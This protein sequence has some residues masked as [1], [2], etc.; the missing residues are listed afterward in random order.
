MA[1]VILQTKAHCPPFPFVIQIGRAFINSPKGVR[2]PK[3]WKET[4]GFYIKGTASWATYEK[5]NIRCI[6]ESTEYIIKDPKLMNTMR[7]GF[8]KRVPGFN[9]LVAGIKRM[10]LAKLSNKELYGL[11]IRFNSAYC[12]TY[13]W[14]EPFPFFIKES[15]AEHLLKYL[16][17]KVDIGKAHKYLNV[18]CSP[19]EISFIKR[20]ERDMLKL[21][22]KI[23][24][25]P[26]LK[27]RLLEE[28]TKDYFWIPYDY[29]P[30]L[31]TRK[32]F[33]EELGDV[34]KNKDPARE[35]KKLNDYYTNLKKE[36][37]RII[38]E[39]DIDKRHQQ[40]FEDV[41]ICAFIMDY[42]KE[43][44]TKSHF[45]AR[46]LLK[47]TAKRL[48]LSFKGVQYISEHEMKEGLIDGKKLDKGRMEKRENLSYIYYTRKS[49][50]LID[51]EKAG[52]FIADLKKNLKKEGR[53]IKGM[54]A[55]SGS[56]M[57]RVSIVMHPR[58]LGKMK[59]GDVLV[60]NMTSPDFVVG[61]KKAGAIVTNEGGITSHAAIVSREMGIPCIIGTK[62][63]SKVLKD[64]DIVEVDAN[65][66]IV[67]KVK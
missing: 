8:L 50:D 16:I 54:P 17:K 12:N 57:G 63:A 38:K 47:E 44:F 32:H 13:V 11:W 24:K 48:G 33:E 25:N 49:I 37:K 61:M 46:P 52:R 7:K 43:V 18:L 59:K 9:R 39:L 23:R 41:R 58:G 55:C 56:Y 42:K 26:K 28:H 51:G 67:R 1:L 29:G 21:A 45:A 35:L 30:Q 60:T 36:Q 66:G 3:F 6:R 4:F 20:E 22:L 53:S 62:N 64:G 31:W 19:T 15:L 10:D 40:L 65:K 34:L 27:D 5:D 2:I 14:S